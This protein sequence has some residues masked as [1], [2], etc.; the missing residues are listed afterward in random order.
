MKK[1]ENK[2]FQYFLKGANNSDA[3]STFQVGLAYLKGRGVSCDVQEAASTNKKNR[4]KLTSSEYFM[5]AA[6]LGHSTA[7]QL[8]EKSLQ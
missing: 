8:T 1:D 2:A 7:I 6:R 4:R 3:N 5:E